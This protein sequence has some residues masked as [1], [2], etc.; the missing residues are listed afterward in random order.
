MISILVLLK[1]LKGDFFMNIDHGNQQLT[2]IDQMNL[3][4]LPFKRKSGFDN[5]L[6]DLR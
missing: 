1:K 3:R 2:K 6:A 5:D 4:S